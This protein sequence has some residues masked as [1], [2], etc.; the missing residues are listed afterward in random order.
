[1]PTLSRITSVRNSTNLSY[2]ALT[3]V[4]YRRAPLLLHDMLPQAL[5][6]V[7]V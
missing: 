3:V 2:V 7:R 1:M 6:Q 5:G 4:V